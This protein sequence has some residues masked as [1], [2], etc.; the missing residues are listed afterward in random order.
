M[1]GWNSDEV[2]DCIDTM[3]GINF[4]TPDFVEFLQ[5]FQGGYVFGDIW[6]ILTKGV[7]GQDDQNQRLVFR[8][9]FY[10]SYFLKVRMT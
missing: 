9:R 7:I 1:L 4:T 6:R 5:P 2:D 8:I 10:F 3:D